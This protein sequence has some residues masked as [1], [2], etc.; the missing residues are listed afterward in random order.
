MISINFPKIYAY[1]FGLAIFAYFSL[2]VTSKYSGYLILFILIL[3][4]IGLLAL[5]ERN[6]YDQKDLIFSIIFLL[7]PLV[8]LISFYQFNTEIRELDVNSRFL[9]VLPIYFFLRTFDLKS[10]LIVYGVALAAII[11]GVLNISSHFFGIQLIDGFTKGTGIVS[12]YGSI[13]GI[14]S[15]YFLRYSKN[16]FSIAFLSV[17]GFMGIATSLIMGGR[18]VWVAAIITLI[19]MFFINPQ[20]WNRLERF[21]INFLFFVLFVVSF[22]IPQT[23]VLDRAKNAVSGITEY[24]TNEN[25][26][27]RRGPSVQKRLEMWKSSIYIIQENPFLGIGENNFKLANKKLID[28]GLIKSGIAGYNHPHGQFFST[29]VE[30]GIIGFIAL[31]MLLF[32]PLL[33]CFRLIKNQ[34][35]IFTDEIRDLTSLLLIIT[36]H[37][38]FYALSNGIF[39][40][41]NTTLFYSAMVAILLGILRNKVSKD[42]NSAA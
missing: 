37:Y 6:K 11:F 30:N 14:S 20:G 4:L 5:R 31:L 21:F 39:D 42:S 17:S 15:L 10:T 19:L 28:N 34:F 3:S 27:L 16:L 24:I 12:L 9:F 32:Y 25:S 29:L 26:D 8:S 40:H 38:L 18:G 33:E 41:Q 7:M 23:A 13:F 2:I 1:I 36:L 35:E 22:A